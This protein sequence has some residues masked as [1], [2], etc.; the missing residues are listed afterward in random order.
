MLN[1]GLFGEFEKIKCFKIY[2]PYNNF[3][4]VMKINDNKGRNITKNS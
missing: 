1:Y 3:D 2:F 4:N